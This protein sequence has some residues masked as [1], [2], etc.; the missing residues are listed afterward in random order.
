MRLVIAI[1]TVFLCSFST[2][3]QK[4]TVVLM[5]VKV[6]GK[7]GYINYHGKIIIEPKF[8]VAESF[9]S[10]KYAK[11]VLN[12]KPG[13]INKKGKINKLPA[14]STVSVLIHDF[15]LVEQDGYIGVTDSAFNTI[16]PVSFKA[17]KYFD[18]GSTG[19]RRFNLNGLKNEFILAQGND[20]LWR[21]FNFE[22]KKILP[23]AFEYIAQADSFFIVSKHNFKGIYTTNGKEILPLDY[24]EI[25]FSHDKF[26]IQKDGL[27]G[28]Y[29]HSGKQ[30]FPHKWKNIHV[31]NT[32]W[33]ILKNRDSSLIVN[34]KTFIKLFTSDFDEYVSNA[35]NELLVIKSEKRGL[36]NKEGVE[37]IP[38]KFDY[39]TKRGN[40]Y[41]TVSKGLY[42]LYSITGKEIA[43]PKYDFIDEVDNNLALVLKTRRWGLINTQGEEIV[44]PRYEDIDIGDN[45]AKCKL[46]KKLKIL[47]LNTKGQVTETVEYDNVLTLDINQ[48]SRWRMPGRNTQNIVVPPRRNLLMGNWFIDTTKNLWGLHNQ[49]GDTLIPPVFEK[50]TRTDTSQYAIVQL[51]TK[52]YQLNIAGFNLT[53]KGKLGLVREHDGK[54]IIKPS[55]AFIDPSVLKRNGFAYTRALLLSGQFILISE[56]GGRRLPNCRYIDRQHNGISRAFIGTVSNKSFTAKSKRE[57]WANIFIRDIHASLQKNEFSP[58]SRE[59]VFKDGYWVYINSKGIKSSEKFEY[60]ENFN[61]DRAIVKTKRGYGVI[62]KRFEFIIEPRYSRISYL[63][64]SNNTK[65]LLEEYNTKEGYIDTKGDPIT[66]FNY[67]NVRDFSCGWGQV[68]VY[69]RVKRNV[70]RTFI[71]HMG[72]PIDDK[73]YKRANDFKENIALVRG[74]RR[75][76]YIDIDGNTIADEIRRGTDFSNGKAWI[77]ERGKYILLNEFGEID[78]DKTYKKIT[79]FMQN[80][81]VVIPK[82]KKWI[83]INGEGEQIGKEKYRKAKEFDEFGNCIVAKRKKWG[84][85]NKEGEIIVPFKYR[86]IEDPVNGIYILQK[87]RKRYA[88]YSAKQ[89]DD[90]KKLGKFYFVTAL[91]NNTIVGHKS[92]ETYA[93]TKQGKR[94]VAKGF[95][96]PKKVYNNFCIVGTGSKMGVISYTGDT[97]LHAQYRRLKYLGNNFFFCYTQDR[98]AEGRIIG[99]NG[100]TI[101]SDIEDANTYSEG[102]LSAKKNGKW[103]ILDENGI[104]VVEPKY[105]YIGN[106]KEGL[107]RASVNKN[108]YITDRNGVFITE[109]NFEKLEYEPT[110][111]LY[112]AEVGKRIGYLSPEGK[113]VWFPQQ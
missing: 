105:H 2:V 4:D 52:D 55:M 44:P 31:I 54:M 30:V 78:K 76:K 97:L 65:F 50:V 60:A 19:I 110:A 62:N 3:A 17:V 1:I 102:L 46:G 6:D 101:V 66:G 113:W 8:E 108:T 42:G 11:V 56:R 18:N 83:I 43:P 51:G 22:G 48:V 40:Y 74:Y 95:V 58:F 49:N 98:N 15:L 64:H 12:G 25:G 14:N 21:I 79:P 45:T 9:G 29:Q 13:L 57:N 106:F 23:I 80:R 61:G 32:R 103:G 72:K 92:K 100:L 75:Y 53:F 104:W 67:Q 73:Q 34:T 10:N 36:Y 38:P 16:L 24:Q 68:L 71:D 37:V 5:P 33:S 107:A 47:S 85:I 86:K 41:N 89:Q 94:L 26:I 109:A 81:A 90:I 91:P 27:W 20:S 96:H 7:W 77:K 63:E 111:N 59:L 28:L 99:L 39:F 84:I 35:Y 70:Y 88:T 69:D 112:R 87:T 82:G 93:F